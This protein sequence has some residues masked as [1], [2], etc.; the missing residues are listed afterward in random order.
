MESVLCAM[1]VCT[2]LESGDGDFACEP[3]N[4]NVCLVVV[5]VGGW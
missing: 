2:I 3:V 5:V 1:F 4:V